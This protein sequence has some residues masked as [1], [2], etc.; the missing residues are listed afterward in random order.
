ME[1]PMK[2]SLTLPD[3]V[4]TV[5]AARGML[6]GFSVCVSAEMDINSE[7]EPGEQSS[8]SIPVHDIPLWASTLRENMNTFTPAPM[9]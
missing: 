6:S 3:L 9:D 4:L 7:W 5:N 2:K 8:N 1:T